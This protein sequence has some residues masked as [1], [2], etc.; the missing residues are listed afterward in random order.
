MSSQTDL[1]KEAVQAAARLRARHGVGPAQ[2][3]C[4]YD[5]AIKLEIKVSFLAAPSLEGMYSPEPLPASIILSSE[6]PAGRRRYTC[7]HELG[8]HVFQHGTRIDE[9][10]DGVS[11]PWS[12]EEFLAQR[13]ASALLMPKIAVDAAFARRGWKLV[14]ATS[15]QL[16]VVSQELGVGYGTLIA[17]AEINLGLPKVHADSLRAVSLAKVKAAILGQEAK[18]DVFLVDQHWVRPTVD[19]EVG[20]HI[21]LPQNGTLD[22]SCAVAQPGKR[23]IF[24]AVSQGIAKVAFKDGSQAPTLR[25]SR[26]NYVGLA[27]YR[28]LE[29]ADDE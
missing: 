26:R 6:R 23:M 28:H 1:A 3:L 8:H 29:D 5:L 21:I 24:T 17:N 25:V 18:S 19:V 14:T 9:L 22:G 10:E 4:P 12:A 13:F 16:Y 15:E 20:D 11:S 27:R 7:G 2:G